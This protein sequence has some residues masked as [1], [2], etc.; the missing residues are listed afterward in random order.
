MQR[1][2]MAPTRQNWEHQSLWNAHL[3]KQHECYDPAARC[4]GFDQSDLRFLPAVPIEIEVMGRRD[5]PP[6]IGHATVVRSAHR[7]HIGQAALH[8]IGRIRGMVRS[9]PMVVDSMDVVDPEGGLPWRPPLLR[10]AAFQRVA[11]LSPLL[12]QP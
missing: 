7:A 3:L 10:R 9:I 1:L 6:H 11:D 5:S 4:S 12:S 8:D 2:M